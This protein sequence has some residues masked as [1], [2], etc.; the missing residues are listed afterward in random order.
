[1]SGQTTAVQSK[2]IILISSQT[3][4]KTRYFRIGEILQ[5][6]KIYWAFTVDKEFLKLEAEQEDIL[7]LQE[8]KSDGRDDQH[9]KHIEDLI[10]I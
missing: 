4:P 1:M 6:N 10:I 9:V 3:Y 5:L 2:N 7:V 8:F